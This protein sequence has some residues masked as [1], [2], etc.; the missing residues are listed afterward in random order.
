MN[1][2]LGCQ[3]FYTI[4]KAFIRT[5]LNYS[6]VIYDKTFNESW[7]RI[8]ESAQ[9]KAV[10]ASTCNTNTEELYQELGLESLQNMHKLRR[11][12]LYCKICKD[13]SPLNLFKL[14]PPKTS[15]NY[16]LGNAKEI[17][18]MKRSNRR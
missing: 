15:G 10:L 13:Q 14:I 5:H 6:D 16:P 12:G 8:L 17:L 3:L 7:R 1:L 18:V 11:L 9:C 4:Y 2:L